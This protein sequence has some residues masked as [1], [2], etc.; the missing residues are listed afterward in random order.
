[1]GREEVLCK[2][3]FSLVCPL[4]FVDHIGKGISPPP[5]HSLLLIARLG[6]FMLRSKIFV[7]KSEQGRK[8]GRKHLEEFFGTRSLFEILHQAGANEIIKFL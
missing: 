1:L 4:N 5:R 8:E 7:N 3:I 6:E 2:L